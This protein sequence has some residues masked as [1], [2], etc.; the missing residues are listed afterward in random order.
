MTPKAIIILAVVFTLG[1]VAGLSGTS[2]AI[3]SHRC[4]ILTYGP[5]YQLVRLQAQ[6]I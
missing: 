3:P 5:E 4:P 2:Q 6:K 1:I